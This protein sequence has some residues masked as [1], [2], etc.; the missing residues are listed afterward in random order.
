M[1]SL[2]D[3]TWDE[4]KDRFRMIFD[5]IMYHNDEY[6]ILKDFGSYVEACQ[7]IENLYQ[8]KKHWAHMAI[9]N[10]AQSGYF[11]SDRT[12]NDY[13]NNIWHLQKVNGR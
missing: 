11:S 12:I 9:I 10:I 7:K 6:F 1:D 8:D 13:A 5:E 3:G 4:D 2:I